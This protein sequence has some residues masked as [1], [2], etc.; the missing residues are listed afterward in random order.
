MKKIYPHLRRLLLHLDVSIS[1]VLAQIRK[2][3]S[4]KERNN[5]AFPSE[6]GVEVWVQARSDPGGTT[7]ASK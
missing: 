7:V 2:R 4:R 6:A 1:Y 3:W 5:S